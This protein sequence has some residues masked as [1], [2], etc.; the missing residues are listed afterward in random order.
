MKRRNVI[1]MALLPALAGWMAGPV[2][3]QD[4]WAALTAAARKEGRLVIYNGAGS[5]DVMRRIQQEFQ[6]R[7][8]IQIDTVTGRP[9][10]LR[11]RIRAE[12]STGRALGDVALDGS[13]VNQPA[14]MAAF[15][16]H[17]ALPNAG[18]L[19]APYSD[20]GV[21]MPFAIVRY[22]ILVSTRLV[23]PAD[24]P[25]S[26]AD[27]L[28]PKWSGKI[29]SDDPRAAGG[30][31]AAFDVLN[32][33]LGAAFLEK[34]AAQKPML[35]RDVA[36]NARRIAQGEF[37]LYVP[38]SMQHTPTLKGLP[39]KVVVPREGYPYLPL[40]AALLKDAPHPNAAR[41]FMK[42]LL[43]APA[44]RQIVA[45]GYGSVTGQSHEGAPA[46]L[47]GVSSSRPMGTSNPIDL[48][49]RR[50]IYGAHFGK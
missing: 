34:L 42:Y 9:S 20:D 39:V 10:E 26:W 16:P 45:H 28:A 46:E 3:A 38:F 33:T 2:H 18:S 27:L 25:T 40:V 23:K 17:G 48:D 31:S 15:Q 14:Y 29:L 41:L 12:Q 43:D 8:G 19:V 30:G 49:K 22:G 7:Y 6:A 47:A 13:T 35:S 24:E 50:E 4:A 44:Q 1:G 36:L 32:E 21:L 5:A 11:E 37:P